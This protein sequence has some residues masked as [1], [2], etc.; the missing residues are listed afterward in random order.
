MR[1]TIIILLFIVICILFAIYFTKSHEGI[2]ESLDPPKE[3]NIAKCSKQ[4]INLMNEIY[5]EKPIT[6]IIDTECDSPYYNDMKQKLENMI[7]LRKMPDTLTADTNQLLTADDAKSYL[8]KMEDD[9]SKYILTL[10]NKPAVTCSTVTTPKPTEPPCP[11]PAPIKCIADYGTNIGEPLSGGQGVL[12]DT[13]YVCPNTLK[14]CSHFKCG[15]AFGT[16]T[17]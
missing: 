11:T 14:K 17:S 1:Q 9:M 3:A 7:K 13:R 15:S 16:C 10:L 6:T 4:F 2:D 8:S 12:Q 5:D